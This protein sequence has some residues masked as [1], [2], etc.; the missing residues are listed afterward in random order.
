LEGT[1]WIQAAL[2]DG[3]KK[4]AHAKLTFLPFFFESHCSTG[5]SRQTPLKL[6]VYRQAM[7]KTSSTS[8]S[9]K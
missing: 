9:E 7:Q 3:V 8:A 6:S 5:F 2:L 4:Q 1:W